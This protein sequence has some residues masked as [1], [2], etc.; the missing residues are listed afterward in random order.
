MSIYSASTFSQNPLTRSLFNNKANRIITAEQFYK[1][2]NKTLA[3]VAKRA[4]DRVCIAESGEKYCSEVLKFY[5]SQKEK[6][7]APKTQPNVAIEKDSSQTKPINF[8]KQRSKSVT[9]IKKQYQ[10]SPGSFTAGLFDA[11]KMQLRLE[12]QGPCQLNSP[13]LS[14][15]SFNQSDNSKQQSLNIIVDNFNVHSKLPA[16]ITISDNTPQKN[17][18]KESYT[19]QSQDAYRKAVHQTRLQETQRQLKNLLDGNH[20]R[21]Y[22][23]SSSQN[24]GSPLSDNLNG[25]DKSQRKSNIKHPD[26]MQKFR[27]QLSKFFLPHKKH[28]LQINTLH[29]ANYNQPQKISANNKLF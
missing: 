22:T 4:Q 15:I 26:F 17:Q 10:R 11:D 3:E 13:R 16:H 19:P 8:K 29:P 25:F 28:P 12:R 9:E 21:Q 14:H 5:K 1:N 23:S 24:N 27:D 2:I 6:Q 18:T 7:L 20:Q